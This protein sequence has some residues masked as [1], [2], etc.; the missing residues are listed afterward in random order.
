MSKMK[1]FPA[2][3]ILTLP[4]R[5]LMAVLAAACFLGADVAA[6]LAA[7][8][9]PTPDPALL[10]RNYTAAETFDFD[11]TWAGIPVGR[12]ALT[13]GAAADT[14]DR[15]AIT[16]RAKAAGIMAVLYP[17]EDFFETIVE[18][19]AR[20]P[21][22]MRY[23]QQE[24]GELKKKWVE[25]DQVRFRQVRSR[26][27]NREPREY[28]Y[29]GPV[30]NEFSSFAVLRAL[31]LAA[32]TSFIV[33]TFADEKRHEVAVAV[34]EAEE[35]DTVLLGRVRTLRTRPRLNFSGLYVKTGDPLI[36]FT[37]DGRF[38]PVRIKAPI[39]IGTLTANLVGYRRA[40]AVE[41]VV[42]GGER[43]PEVSVPADLEA[44]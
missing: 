30:H 15:Y 17:D 21:V 39:R 29:D 32:G 14:A 42:K 22:R 18:G 13:M 36:W 1:A 25:Y 7:E 27:K 37:D 16:V 43:L 33:P 12:L 28:S 40:G 3:R 35:V 19:P 6:G 38:I 4:C 9:A 41:L 44:R 24:K 10:A 26:T 2:R 5:I 31:P 20:L 8:P 23:Q 11:V 34:E